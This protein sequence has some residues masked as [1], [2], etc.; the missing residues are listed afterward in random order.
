[1]T[2]AIAFPPLLDLAP[3]Q[4]EKRKQHLLGEI[5][6]DSRKLRRELP[7]PRSFRRSV[8]VLASLVVVL[9]GTVGAGIA[10]SMGAF[11]GLHAAQHPLGVT[12]VFDPATADYVKTHLAGIQIE[13]AR[14]VGELP[15]NQKVYVITGTQND[16]C[17]VLQPP[18]AT[19]WCGAPLSKEHPATLYAYPLSDG[20]HISSWIAFGVALDGVTSITFQPSE[21]AGS[22][23]PDVTVPVKDN[24]WVHEGHDQ[25]GILQPVTARFVDGTTVTEPATG[26]NCAAC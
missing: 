6:G 16:L 26:T 10:A 20:T 19:A 22:T 12:D 18:N 25:P 17:T 7:R 11:D 1:M 8:V 5:A 4:L 9:L 15:D 23:G 21:T 24:L 2:D 13:T 14:H 3:G